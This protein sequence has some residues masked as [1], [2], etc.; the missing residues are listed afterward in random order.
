MA[1][2]EPAARVAA[3][4]G[5]VSPLGGFFAVAQRLDRGVWRPMSELRDDPTAMRSRIDATGAGLAK[6]SRRSAATLDAKAVASTTHLALA[7]RL[8]SPAVASAVLAGVVPAMSLAAAWWQPHSPDPTPLALPEAGGEIVGP[9][10]PLRLA[11]TLHR[12][13]IDTAMRDL[14]LS[15]QA[16][17]AVSA[18]VLWGNVASALA[19]AAALVTAVRPD[20]AA[21]ASQL[22]AAVLNRGELADAGSFSGPGRRFR[23]RSCCLFYRLPEA[24]LCGDCVLLAGDG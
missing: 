17:Q 13:V 15:T 10:D 5:E 3:V 4:L 24:G 22:V 18:Q 9:D 7:A 2:P 16:V 19:T 6:R 21:Q 1:S 23:R 11:A 8:L 20:R 14:V 12:L